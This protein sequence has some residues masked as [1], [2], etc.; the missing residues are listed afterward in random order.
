LDWSGALPLCCGHKLKGK[1]HDDGGRNPIWEQTFYVQFTSRGD[2]KERTVTFHVWDFNVVSDE[3]IGS[4]QVFSAGDLL[5]LE[6]KKDAAWIPLT[7]KDG[8]TAGEMSISA[9]FIP[10]IGVQVLEAKDIRDVQTFG[11][12]DPYVK[13]N[14]GE[15]QKYSTEEHTDGAT[16]PK[17]KSGGPWFFCN[18]PGVDTA[19]AKENAFIFTI[20]DANPVLDNT[21]GHV[22]IP[23][24]GLEKKKGAGPQ[25]FPV[26]KKL[27]GKDTQGQLCVD[28]TAFV[29]PKS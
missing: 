24:S 19:E 28:V 21:I 17:W 9:K 5:N 23:W 20:M 22:Q 18:N 3:K 27:G 11:K 1:P 4:S 14:L 12:Q 16:N 7:G 8:K 29:L 6:A 26:L 15:N 2:A 10:G 25:W 13:V